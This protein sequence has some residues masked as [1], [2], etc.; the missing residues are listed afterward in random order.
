VERKSLTGSVR[1]RI[2]CRRRSGILPPVRAKRG[3]M[4]RPVTT[5]NSTSV[6][7]Q[8]APLPVIRDGVRVWAPRAVLWTLKEF[9]SSSPFKRT[10][11][12]RKPAFHD[13]LNFLGFVP[14]RRHVCFG[15]RGLAKIMRPEV[16]DR[17]VHDP[18]AIAGVPSPLPDIIGEWK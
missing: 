3:L 7:S 5:A 17:D 16:P 13:C 12:S 2:F 1:A 8:R 11:F 4:T 15:C 18:K 6:P 14:A 9:V 10:T